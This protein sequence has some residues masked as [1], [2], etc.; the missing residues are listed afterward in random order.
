M[1][2]RS[3]AATQAAFGAGNQSMYRPL[4]AFAVIVA[5]GLGIA[6]TSAVLPSAEPPASPATATTEKSS[7]EKPAPSAKR[8][9]IGHAH[10][11]DVGAQVKLPT[12][13]KAGDPV[14]HVKSNCVRCHLT[15]GREL[16]AP[17]QDFARSVHD[18]QGMTCS[19]CHGGNREKDSEAHEGEFGFIGT[20]LSAHMAG[21]AECHSEQAEQVKSGP[22]YWD[23]SKKINLAYPV[24]IDCHGH[25][26]IE[27]PPQEFAL[28]TVCTECHLRFEQQMPAI[29]SVV[30]ENDRLWAVLRKVQEKNLRNEH[31]VPEQ[32]HRDLAHA[33][34]LTARLIHPATKIST[35]EAAQLNAEVTK[36]RAQLE[37]YLANAAASAPSSKG[38]T[39]HAP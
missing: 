18:L 16:T 28:K 13:W 22:H 5:C 29:A 26:D 36:I 3:R 31:P 17:A 9:A 30:T 35:N 23:F 11:G 34:Q 2:F 7:K 39:S 12:W 4:A 8:A 21:C 1:P 38:R 32:F 19:D 33:R 25:H 15:A 37:S 10:A 24:C 20:K 27:K 6:V 14:P